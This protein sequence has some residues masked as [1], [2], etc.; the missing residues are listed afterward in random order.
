MALDS[1]TGEHLWE[2]QTDAGVNA[3]ASVFE[4]DGEQYVV[5]FS[6]GN[7]F[8][9]GPRGDSVWLFSLKGLCQ[10]DWHRGKTGPPGATPGNLADPA[11]P[12][13]RR[14]RTPVARHRTR[15]THPG[16]PGSDLH[17]LLGRG[18]GFHTFLLR[19]RQLAA[20]LL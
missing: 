18:N 7:Q 9:R 16:E 13:G 17:S 8:G 11:L 6:A 4:Q 12:G 1:A 10:T 15:G 5:V 19:R 3:P 20:Q 2:F 14:H